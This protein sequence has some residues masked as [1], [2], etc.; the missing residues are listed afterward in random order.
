MDVQLNSLRSLIIG[1]IILTGNSGIKHAEAFIQCHPLH[2]LATIIFKNIRSVE[3]LR[4]VRCRKKTREKAFQEKIHSSSTLN[5][6]DPSTEFAW[7]LPKKMSLVASFCSQHSSWPPN[8]VLPCSFSEFSTFPY[9]FSPIIL[10]LM[11]SLGLEIRCWTCYPCF[12]LNTPL[13]LLLYPKDSKGVFRTYKP[14]QPSWGLSCN[15][16]SKT[17]G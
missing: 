1:N 8:T 14:M 9:Q 5:T 12:D 2:S 11:N 4:H 13:G 6:C 10:I 7:E 3:E 15:S 16:D 17:G